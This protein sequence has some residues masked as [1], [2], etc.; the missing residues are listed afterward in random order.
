MTT[1]VIKMVQMDLHKHYLVEMCHVINNHVLGV[2][3][4]LGVIAP[5]TAEE[6][7]EAGIGIVFANWIQLTSL[8]HLPILAMS[9][10]AHP[11]QT[12]QL[13][14]W[15]HVINKL[16]I[17]LLLHANGVHGIH[18]LSAL[19]HVVVDPKLE[20]EDVFAVIRLTNQIHIA[21]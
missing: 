2:H 21:K 11:N 14:K 17:V 19:P 13:P 3:G 5:H 8:Q 10:C 4:S 6:E 9:T 7:Q 18:G 1:N 15:K 20:T 12:K 16:A